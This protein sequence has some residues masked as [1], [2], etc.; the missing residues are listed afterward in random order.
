MRVTDRY[1]LAPSDDEG[2][3]LLTRCDGRGGATLVDG[4]VLEA[5]HA[6]GDGGTLVW[7][8]D[9]WIELT[10]FANECRYR[11]EVARTA[12]VR[13]RLPAGWRYKSRLR[14]HRLVVRELDG[15]R[16]R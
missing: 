14:R 13:L 2:R 3:A 16:T 7:L 8:S 6:L 11:L 12:A 9:D 1:A 15:G 5:Q 4:I 10:F